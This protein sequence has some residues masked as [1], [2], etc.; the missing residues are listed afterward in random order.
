[1]K[2]NI[3]EFVNVNMIY[4]DGYVAIEDFNL[5][6]DSGEFVTLLGPSGCGKTTMLKIIGGFIYPTRG[7][8]LYNGIDIK[9]ISIAKR[10]TATVFQ[11]YALF[12]NMT[13]RQNIEYGLKLMRAP[14]ENVSKD[15]S[16]QANKI[17]QS[18]QKLANSKI[19]DIAKTQENIKK[20]IEKLS[21][22]YNKNSFL[23]SIKKMNK[24]EYL[25]TLD[26]YYE[27]LEKT[28]GTDFVSKIS[29]KNKI[30]DWFNS[31]F[32]FFSIPYQFKIS[33]KKMNEIEKEI[34]NLKKWYRYKKP[35]DEKIEVLNEKFDDLDYNISY[36]QNYANSKKESY[37]KKYLTRKLNKEE[38]RKKSNDIIKLVGL[39]GKENNYPDEL[40]GGMKQ[41]VALARALVIEPE[42]VL[43][44]EPL[45]AL[46]AK[47]RSQLQNELKRL[48]KESGLTFILV[49]H[50]QEEALMLS[51]KIVVMSQGK[52]E[53][54]GTS[55]EIYDT[56]INPWVAKF[57]GRINIFN[58]Q[59][60]KNNEFIFDS[61]KY[62]FNDDISFKPKDHDNVLMTIRPEDFEI[63]DSLGIINN[64]VIV[65]IIYK[66]IMYDIKCK[67]NDQIIN[68]ESTKKYQI[69][70]NI[71][72]AVDWND[73]HFI[74]GNNNE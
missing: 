20:S 49:T 9:D 39:V 35:I 60:L 31:I 19:R 65:D 43:L 64:A 17:Y 13:V 61:K 22:K 36:W 42:I 25:S 11:D 52:I 54:V 29:F 10:P 21:K 44:D 56:P 33:S 38:I 30:F 18:A 7:K 70:S 6:I 5:S 53:Q 1:M 62:K 63:T 71:N 8:I 48:H 15:I 47:V 69:N 40:S 74:R 66:G 72:L 34:Y 57:I 55:N 12:P 67:W 14:L 23:Q 16:V 32:S 73:I 28:Y 68:V 50:D 3:L 26:K 37:E 24:S 46:D 51:D 45:G 58:V 4:D 41:R 2:K 27:Q 59:A